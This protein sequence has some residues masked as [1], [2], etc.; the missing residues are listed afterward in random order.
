MPP[1]NNPLRFFSVGSINPSP[2]L[3]CAI[4]LHTPAADFASTSDKT[5]YWRND[6]GSIDKEAAALG[7]AA[8][9]LYRYNY[10]ES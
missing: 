9:E 7:A 10:H 2:K 1:L 6:Y 8:G 5:G 3:G 4:H